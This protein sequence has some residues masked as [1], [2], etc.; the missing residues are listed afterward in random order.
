MGETHKLRLFKTKELRN[1]FGPKKCEVCDHFKLLC[2]KGLNV[3]YRS[4]GNV[5]IGNLRKP[6]RTWHVALFLADR[7]AQNI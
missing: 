3:L 2:K 1:T 6:P 7:E 5:I 4:L